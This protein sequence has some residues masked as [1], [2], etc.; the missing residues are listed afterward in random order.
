MSE[1]A[2]LLRELF[3]KRRIVRIIGA[4]HG[5][6]AKLIERAGFDGVWASGLEISTAHAVPDANILTMTENLDA[7]RA[8]NDA[9]VIPVVCDCDTGYGNAANVIHMV[10]KYEAAG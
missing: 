4:H 5:L 1:K 10:K 9:C 3:E 2:G 6:G 7:A 8:I